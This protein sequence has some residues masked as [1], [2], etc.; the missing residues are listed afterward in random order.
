MRNLLIL[1]HGLVL[2][3][4]KIIFAFIFLT[5][6]YPVLIKII[7]TQTAM[8]RIKNNFGGINNHIVIK[9]LT[10][11]FLLPRKYLLERHNRRE[12][13]RVN[14]RKLNTILKMLRSIR[15][16]MFTKMFKCGL[17]QVKHWMDGS[18]YGLQYVTT[19]CRLRTEDVHTTKCEKNEEETYESKVRQI[20]PI[21]TQRLYIVRN[22][23]KRN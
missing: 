8:R 1:A 5:T 20:K 16:D 15:S 13:E 11:F 22:V 10:P 21:V 23:P 2:F 3:Q 17:T 9:I 14:V 6:H 18:P 12:L 7:I 4:T 19:V